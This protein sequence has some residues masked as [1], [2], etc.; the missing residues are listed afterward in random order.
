MTDEEWKEFR[1]DEERRALL[2]A[3]DP[4]LDRIPGLEAAVLDDEFS[5][6]LDRRA[7]EAVVALTDEIDGLSLPLFYPTLVEHFIRARISLVP[8]NKSARTRRVR[9]VVKLAEILAK[10]SDVAREIPHHPAWC[11]SLS[12]SLR[13]DAH[14][15]LQFAQDDI[16][17]RDVSGAV[18]AMRREGA[19]R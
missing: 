1:I 14:Q 5:R 3:V 2:I 19:P 16:A 11:R 18:L 7:L 13:G 15:L 10:A 9:R 6:C 17:A 12:G 8:L 4:A